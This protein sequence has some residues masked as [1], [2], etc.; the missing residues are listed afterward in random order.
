M[1]QKGPSFIAKRRHDSKNRSGPTSAI[2]KS[3]DTHFYDMVTE[4]VPAAIYNVPEAD[5]SLITTLPKQ[6][7]VVRFYTFVFFCLLYTIIVTYAY[8]KLPLVHPA[9]IF[10]PHV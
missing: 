8:P 5:Y 7:Q 9:H 1:P 2:I 3:G 6:K 10:T 4:D